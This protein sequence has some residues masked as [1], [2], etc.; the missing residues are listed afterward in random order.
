MAEL[1]EAA[2]I[3]M[4]HL[5]HGQVFIGHLG[6]R[7]GKLS[8]WQAIARQNSFVPY[9]TVDGHSVCCD[10]DEA[11]GNVSAA[12]ISMENCLTFLR[13]TSPV[14]QDPD[15]YWTEGATVRFHA[16]QIEIQHRSKMKSGSR[17]PR[18]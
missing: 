16:A 12:V 1:G 17:V 15:T 14:V 13:E 6:S 10:I 2:M 3:D 18:R 5:S 7:F 4:W 8:W 11:C 9:F